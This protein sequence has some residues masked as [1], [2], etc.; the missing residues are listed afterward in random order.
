MSVFYSLAVTAYA[1]ISHTLSLSLSVNG[2]FGDTDVSA[3]I[4]PLCI[5]AYLK[6]M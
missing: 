5:T 4:G 6:V 1:I 2:A 3:F